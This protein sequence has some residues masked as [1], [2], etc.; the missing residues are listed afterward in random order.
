MSDPGIQ[1]VNQDFARYDQ[2][3]K[4]HSCRLVEKS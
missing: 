1:A 2:V 3:E 4:I